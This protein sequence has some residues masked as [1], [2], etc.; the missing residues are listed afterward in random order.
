MDSF[1]DIFSGGAMTQS[2]SVATMLCCRLTLILRI[3]VPDS[4]AIEPGAL[5]RLCSSEK[6][7]MRGDFDR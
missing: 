1:P 6:A 3:E 7:I 5:V 2:L 4:F